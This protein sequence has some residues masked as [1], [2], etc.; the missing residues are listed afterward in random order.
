MSVV[1][2]DVGGEAVVSVV[3]HF[4]DRGMIMSSDD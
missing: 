4:T 3:S 1:Q 2:T